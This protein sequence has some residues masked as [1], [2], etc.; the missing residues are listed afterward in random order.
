MCKSKLQLLPWV[1]QFLDLFVFENLLLVT[2]KSPKISKRPSL[3][4]K[5]DGV[6]EVVSYFRGIKMPWDRKAPG[7]LSLTTRSFV[8]VSTCAGLFSLLKPSSGQ[9]LCRIHRCIPG[10]AL[11]KYSANIVEEV[12]IKKSNYTFPC[13]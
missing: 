12:F 1:S 6:S 10:V 2:S 7:G 4:V 11:S 8:G 9:G 3:F 5:A 13:W